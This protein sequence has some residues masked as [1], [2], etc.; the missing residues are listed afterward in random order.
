L[1]E[2]ERVEVVE[3]LKGRGDGDDGRCRG[4]VF[5]ADGVQCVG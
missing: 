3:R 5:A 1:S 4:G 2:A